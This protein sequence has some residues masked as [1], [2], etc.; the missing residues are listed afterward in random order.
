MTP[1]EMTAILRAE[2]KPR[3]FMHTMGVVATAQELAEI[4]GEDESRAQLAGLLH[5]NA[6]ALDVTELRRIAEEA[7]LDLDE[8]ETQ[9]SALLHAP[10][11]AYLA[12][13][14]FMVS[15]EQ[16]LSAIRYHTTGK[17]NMT[18]L[19]AIIYIADM[20]E[21]N[22]DSFPGLD[23]LRE[24]AK[25]DIYLAL[26]YG[27]KRSNDYVLQRGHTLF[28]RSARAYDW[29]RNYNRERLLY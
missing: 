19:E 18:Q 10:V 29:A 14:R 23:K 12:R 20:I 4:H 21:P 28:A 9:T 1:E 17:P 2:L 27:L 16:V 26:E 6:K 3:R 5:D 8:G 25:Q 13:T 7:A 15:D 22:R 11:G 24:L